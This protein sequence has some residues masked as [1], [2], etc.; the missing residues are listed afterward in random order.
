MDKVR[1]IVCYVFAGCLLVV[2]CSSVVTRKLATG[3]FY[4]G[5]GFV[6]AGFVLLLLIEILSKLDNR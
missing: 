4:L 6:W 2:G 1:R 3:E 5:M